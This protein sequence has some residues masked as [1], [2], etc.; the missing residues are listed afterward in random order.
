MRSRLPRRRASP[1]RRRS[2][3][4]PARTRD[5]IADDA[6]W[7]RPQIEAS[8]IAWARSRSSSSS[9][10]TPSERPAG[11]EAREQLLLAHRPDAARDALAA[12]LVA[13]ER[14]D[15]PEGVREVGRLVERRSRR[16]SPSVAPA[17]R[18]AL[19]GQRQVQRVRADEDARR[20]AQEDRLD[21]PAVRDAARELE[22]LAPA[23]RRTRPRRRPA[24][25]RGPRRR[26][27]SGP[28]EPSVPMR[29][30][31]A[32]PHRRMSGTLA[33][34]STLLTAVGLPNRPTSTGNG[35]LL[36]GSPRLPSIDSNSA[37]SSPQ[38]YA[39]APRRS[40][41]SNDQ[42]LPASR[43]PGGLRR[44]PG[45]WRC[46]SGARGERVLAAEVEVAA[47]GARRRSPR[48]SSPR[49]SRTGPPP[50]ARGP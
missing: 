39:P 34:V 2:W 18:V 1:Q 13:E 15:A 23:S 12:R 45:R 49:R 31:A 25:R 20:A 26:T 22:Q 4:R 16:R 37:V 30:Y 6:V 17:A 36:R 46:A 11:G 40:S 41:M 33:S 21:R 35:G 24:S 32:A 10:S 27:A 9:S 19:E 28:V 3:T 14:G 38:M 5:S 42:P 8:R 43:R 44:A 50:G 48:S 29:A 7:P 47:L